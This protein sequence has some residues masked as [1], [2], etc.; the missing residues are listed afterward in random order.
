MYFIAIFLLVSGL[1][2]RISD[3]QLL[4]KTLLNDFAHLDACAHGIDPLDWLRA[5]I[6]KGKKEL[7]D[8]DNGTFIACSG[9]AD[10]PFVRN[11]IE[12]HRRSIGKDGSHLPLF[13]SI[14]EE[15]S[16][17]YASEREDLYCHSIH[18]SLARRFGSTRR[19]SESSKT[20]FSVLST[21]QRRLRKE[22]EAETSPISSKIH[23]VQYL[24][25]H[26]KIDDSLVAAALMIHSGPSPDDEYQRRG[27]QHA[28]SAVLHR[29]LHLQ[30]AALARI[31]TST[32]PAE[33]AEPAE[34]REEPVDALEM[35]LSL[36]PR[37]HNRECQKTLLQS[38][39]SAMQ[40]TPMT[41]KN[42]KS[43]RL[44]GR[45]V[46]FPSPSAFA[47]PAQHKSCHRF[48]DVAEL[49][50]Q[51]SASEE[52]ERGVQ[53]AQ[54]DHL[55][56]SLDTNNNL[57]A[58]R[59]LGPIF[60]RENLVLR[61]PLPRMQLA[62]ASPTWPP[63]WLDGPQ[64][65]RCLL[66]LASLSAAATHVVRVG[67]SPPLRAQNLLSR[68]IMQSGLTAASGQVLSAA[69]LRGKGQV[70]GMADTG[71]DEQSCYFHDD[72]KGLVP[73]TTAETAYFD[74]TRRKVVQYVSYSGSQGDSVRGHGSHVAGTVAGYCP[75]SNPAAPVANQWEGMAP[76]A[77][78][79]FF[80]IGKPG[81]NALYVPFD[82]C[83]D[84]FPASYKAGA[85]LFS[86]SWGGGYWYDN[87]A[88]E[89]DRFMFLNP[90]FLA[91]FAAG[92][93]G[94]ARGILSPSLC[95]NGFAV[96]SVS[97]IDAS[98][99][100]KSS[101]SST[102]PTQDGRMKPEAAAPG[103]DV[104]SAA[105]LDERND[106]ASC[107]RVRKSGTSMATPAMAGAAALLRQY[108]EDANFWAA[109]CDVSFGR[110]C[111]RGGGE[112]E[113]GSREGTHGPFGGDGGRQL[114]G[115][116]VKS[117]LVHAARPIA[118]ARSTP[119]PDMALGY[120]QTVLSRIL[121][122]PAN[123][124]QPATWP[125]AAQ[126]P[127]PTQ[128]LYCDQLLLTSFTQ[129]VYTLEVT[130]PS[131]PLRATI[132][133][134]DPPAEAFSARLLLHDVDLQLEPP[135]PHVSSMQP[136]AKT[137]EGS[138]AEPAPAPAACVY[139]G[140]G[141]QECLPLGSAASSKS[142]ETNPLEQI[143]VATPAVGKWVLRIEAKFLAPYL[144]HTEGEARVGLVLT[145]GGS[146]AFEE[147][148]ALS[149]AALGR[150][151]RCQRQ[152]RAQ[153]DTRSSTHDAIFP[154]DVS[155]LNLVSSRG[156]DR[157]TY[158]VTALPISTD[159]YSGMNSDEGFAEVKGGFPDQAY[160]EVDNIC[161]PQGCFTVKLSDVPGFDNVAS[162]QLAL[163]QCTGQSSVFLSRLH[164]RQTF[165]VRPGAS[166]ADQ[167]T[168]QTAVQAQAQAQ[169]QVQEQEPG[170][171]TCTPGPDAGCSPTG[172]GGV[173]VRL[174]L[175]DFSGLGWL[176]G[177]FTVLGAGADPT[178]T[179]HAGTLLLGEEET[180]DI[181][182][183]ASDSASAPAPSAADP[184]PAIAPASPS[185][186]WLFGLFLPASSLHSVGLS[187]LD[188]DPELDFLGLED[189]RS[190]LNNPSYC[191]AWMN[192]TVTA[193]LVCAEVNSTSSPPVPIDGSLPVDAGNVTYL[194]ALRSSEGYAGLE[195]VWARSVTATANGA[196]DMPTG[197][198]SLYAHFLAAVTAP[199]T[200][201]PLARVMATCRFGSQT[202]RRPGKGSDSGPNSDP[203]SESGVF[204]GRN[205]LDNPF[206]RAIGLGGLPVGDV[207]FALAVLVLMVGAA[208]CIFSQMCF[209]WVDL[210]LRPQ[211]GPSI[212][213]R[214]MRWL[215][216]FIDQGRPRGGSD[217][218]RGHRGGHR[219]PQQRRGPSGDAR[220]Y[221]RVLVAGADAD[222]ASPGGGGGGDLYMELP[223]LNPLRFGSPP[224]GVQTGPREEEPTV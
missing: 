199:A 21:M 31:R 133:W 127:L 106:G 74:S 81:S 177:Q 67:I 189:M 210:A 184:A 37:C 137:E 166:T 148:S 9:Y 66:R 7:K 219:Q 44:F 80:D 191:P 215:E 223:V 163:P 144:Q 205:T 89:A 175:A 118:F 211:G 216:L 2:G 69:G 1:A 48:A 152:P 10:A 63:R 169:A 161:L 157:A 65:A 188:A 180:R 97:H 70:V 196:A 88:R 197:G 86:S 4:G 202:T 131:V 85:N 49:W 178:K 214:A 83:T 111:A 145:L 30:H 108:F 193:A 93:D 73:R 102:G 27:G 204:S 140:N 174:V 41:G 173:V 217:P 115:S 35:H 23:F 155:K 77:K 90:S 57:Q 39:K 168:T 3:G 154:L 107:E 147:Q 46:Q 29:S 99:A 62:E 201:T 58:A 128:R 124:Q 16:V 87:Y 91:L 170:A 156:W 94:R 218:G 123:A 194:G 187:Q 103:E 162:T 55:L 114:W 171:W 100:R 165:C 71:L 213:E 130:D 64:A 59:D 117:A 26:M 50:Q 45:P 207:M 47:K 79:A 132:A 120:G 68:G 208:C 209:F 18:G 19:A 109:T 6:V 24:L 190:P 40:D 151:D 136:S 96:A 179:V 54:C 11:A 72:A 92:N 224:T 183:P 143:E 192:R 25:Q 116:T 149:R 110:T 126:R 206:L 182:L 51:V 84:M 212:G 53:L 98:V 129:V 176:G 113:E 56:G 34:P 32:A 82:L 17:F 42:L 172:R 60:R 119:P 75:L 167:T 13:P 76:D 78:L 195:G 135:E 112:G 159:A 101:F 36:S 203:G 8:S 142:D 141:G 164:P 5:G 104:T 138:V 121:T 125:T 200:G 181:C 150:L 28:L 33:P 14:Q 134:A 222:S 52:A 122:V 220:L 139:L 38:L 146:A 185:F 158:T 22:D 20:R 95:K 105:A 43:Q 153:D 198:S 160:S 221:E 15:I 186:C 61:L 12:A